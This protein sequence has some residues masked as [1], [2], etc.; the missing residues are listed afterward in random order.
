MSFTVFLQGFVDS[1]RPEGEW[2]A[3]VCSRVVLEL[4]FAVAES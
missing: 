2:Y 4:E 1:Y 3:F